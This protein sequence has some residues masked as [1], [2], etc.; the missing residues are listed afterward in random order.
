VGDFY[1]RVGGCALEGSYYGFLLNEE[2]YDV[3][4]TKG[5]VVVV[6]GKRY[7]LRSRK[8]GIGDVS[9]EVEDG[10]GILEGKLYKGLGMGW[11][12]NLLIA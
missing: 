10:L 3:G 5:K 4:P 8:E 1:T 9:R 2:S 12:Y 7:N 6:E 11:K